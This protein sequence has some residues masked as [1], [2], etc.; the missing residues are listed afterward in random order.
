MPTQRAASRT[1]GEPAFGG[2]AHRGQKLL[3]TAAAGHT[4]AQM[5]KNGKINRK[6]TFLGSSFTN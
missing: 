5:P 3:H 4:A 6:L 1:A 2:Q